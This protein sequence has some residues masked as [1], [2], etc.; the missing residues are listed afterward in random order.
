MNPWIQLAI[1]GIPEVRDILVAVFALRK[2]Y[3]ELTQ[4]QV[5]TI[6]AE[7]TAQ[8]DAGFDSAL[9]KMAA[10]KLAHP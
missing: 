7:I 3:P 1:V 2:R 6:T 4:E 8:S 9:A 5:Q 10:D